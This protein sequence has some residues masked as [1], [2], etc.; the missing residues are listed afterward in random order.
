MAKMPSSAGGWADING[1]SGHEFGGALWKNS[2]A[3]DSSCFCAVY[4]RC[5]LLSKGFVLP[6]K[7]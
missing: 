4:V 2:I 7:E 1:N 6:Y 3:F 5:V